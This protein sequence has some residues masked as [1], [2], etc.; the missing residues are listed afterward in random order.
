MFLLALPLLVFPMLRA[1]AEQI[2]LTPVDPVWRQVRNWPASDFMKLFD[3]N[4]PWQA[5]ASAVHGFE[6]SKRFVLEAADGD[7]ERVITG[8]RQRNI[9]LGV[10]GTPLVASAECG[11]GIEGHGPPHDMLAVAQRLRRL[12]AELRY[13]IFDEPLYYGNEFRG[14]LGIRAC[15]SPIRLLAQ[16]AAAKMTELKRVF[17]DVEIG[18][19]EPFGIPELDQRTWTEHLSE[20][21]HEYAIAAGAPLSFFRADIVWRRPIWRSQFETAARFLRSLGM[22]LGIVYDGSPDAASD[23]EWTDMALSN[24][25]MVECQLGI[26]P[27]QAVFQSWMDRPR[28]IL[29]ETE[30]GTLTN[31]VLRYAHTRLC[32]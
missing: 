17:P 19:I 11:L 15:H 7:L 2:W 25:T 8:L 12:G 14:S 1:N 24:A 5:T 20:W 29:P 4:S 21:L 9:A 32:R 13:V 6:L 18:G 10:Q 31:L 30:P 28:R 26:K 27:A 23:R 22:P 3:N 16:Q